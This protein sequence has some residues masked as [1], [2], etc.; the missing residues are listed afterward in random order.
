MFFQYTNGIGNGEYSGTERDKE[1]GI[2]NRGG[3]KE[4]GRLKKRRS[5]I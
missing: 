2:T 3:T 4:G 5:H 1:R